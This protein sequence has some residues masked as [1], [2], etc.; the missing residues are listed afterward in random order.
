MKPNGSIKL[1]SGLRDLQIIDADGNRCGIV[2]EIEF[3]GTPG[4]PLTVKAILVG[5]GAYRG[6]L[7][8]WAFWFVRLLAGD[9]IVRVPWIRVA[10]IA[11][12]VRLSCPA[13]ELGLRKAEDRARRYLPQKGA[14]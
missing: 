12:E 9:R 6:R 7:P 2:D 3:D 8:N 4:G 13:A 14:L 11:S 5:P 1:V 10:S